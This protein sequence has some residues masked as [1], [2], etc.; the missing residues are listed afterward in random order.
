MFSEKNSNIFKTACV[1][2]D[3]LVPKNFCIYPKSKVYLLFS[4]RFCI[5]KQEIKLLSWEK[6]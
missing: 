4:L 5:H 2:Q 1:P 6:Q 3:S